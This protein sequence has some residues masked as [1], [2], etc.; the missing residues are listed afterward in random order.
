M[1]IDFLALP[2]ITA[3]NVRRHGMRQDFSQNFDVKLQPGIVLQWKTFPRPDAALATIYVRPLAS[4]ILHH[5]RPT[6]RFAKI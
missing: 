4:P 5:R 2:S 6:W 1:E 3:I